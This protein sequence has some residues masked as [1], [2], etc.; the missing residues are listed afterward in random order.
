MMIEDEEVGI[1]VKGGKTCI[2]IFDIDARGDG[3]LKDRRRG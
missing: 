3:R 2:F 1:R